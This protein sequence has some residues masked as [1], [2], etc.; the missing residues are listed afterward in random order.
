L[1]EIGFLRQPAFLTADTFRFNLQCLTSG[2]PKRTGTS[3]QLMMRGYQIFDPGIYSVQ[4]SITLT[5]VE[6]TDRRV[7]EWTRQWSEA[8]RD[9]AGTFIQLSADMVLRQLNNQETPN[10]EYHLLW[11]FLE[12]NDP[13]SLDGSTSDPQQ[14]SWTLKYIDF[15]EY[16]L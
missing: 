6:Y 9:K 2:I 15:K 5:F 10:Y 13:G 12:D 11:C 8:L 3:A 1:W 4:G 14:P 16:S 7:R